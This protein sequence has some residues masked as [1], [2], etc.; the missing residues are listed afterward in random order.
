MLTQTKHATGIDPDWIL[1]DSQSTISVFRNPKTLT[2]IRKSGR[3]LRAITNGGY[4]D[5]DMVG[6][7]PNLGEVWYNSNS[8][9]NILSLAD[10]RKVCRVTMDSLVDPSMHV[11]RLDGSVMR[12]VE[13]ESGQYVYAPVNTVSANVHAYTMVSTVAEHKKMFSPRAIKAADAARA[14]YRRIGR[15]SKADF[16][17]ILRN[18]LIRNCPVTPDDAKRAL[19]IYGPDISALKGKTVKSTAEARAP[20]F[21]AVPLPAPIM[22]HHRNVTL[23]LDFFFVQGLAFFHTISRDIGFR[24]VSHVSNRSKPTILKETMAA[25]HL[26]KTRGL[27]LCDIHAD[28]EF[29]CIREDLRPVHM[30]IVPADSHVGEVE[31]SVRTIKERLRSC[32]H[33]LPFKRLPKLM[34]THM[35]ADTVRCLNQFPWQHGVSDKLSPTSIITGAA[36]PDFNNMRLEFGTYVQ[37]FEDNDPT[38]TPKARSLGAIALNPTGNA[39]GD[40]F[41]MSLAT[42]AK[43]SRHQWTEL[44]L[45]D[46]AIARVE[47]IALNEGQPLIQECGLVV[48][49]RPNQPIDDSEYD[50]DYTPPA[51]ET[52]NTLT[53]HDFDPIDND[54]LDD[55]IADAP[56]I[57]PA[58][59]SLDQ[60]A[61]EEHPQQN[62][63]ENE[64][65]DDDDDQLADDDQENETAHNDQNNEE[66]ANQDYEDYGAFVDGDNDD[67][68]APA[69][70]DEELCGNNNDNDDHENDVSAHDNQGLH[71]HN[72]DDDGDMREGELGSD[73]QDGNESY[74][75][76]AGAQPYYNLRTRNTRNDTF[77]Q[78]M[79][80]PHNGKSYFPPTHLLQHEQ[81]EDVK[82]YVFAHVMT[83]MSAKVAIRKHGKA[84]EAA[85][86]QEFA[87]LEALNVYDPIDPD[88][89]TT[90]QRREALRAINLIK[91]KRDGRLKGRTVADGRPQRSMYDKSETAS[92]TV[93]TDALL[94]SIIIDA[95]EGRDV[96]T[97][98]VAG[99]YLKADMD[100]F[101]VMKFTGESVDILCNL[102]PKHKVFVTIKDNVKVLYV[103]LV[104]AMYG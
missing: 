66:N 1:L 76:G 31:R 2:N 39:Q 73:T 6:D 15:P 72:D 59:H 33:G 35:V 53:E 43:I 8:I 104:K 83:Q 51:P 42:G 87:Q 65:A 100:D 79:D 41:F 88:T 47:A 16:Q 18:N 36:S 4:Q 82:R 75:G 71:G 89:L 70:D 97:A 24:T 55:L 81:L 22:E 80:N 40:Y 67:N 91:E 25:I 50:R 10:V 74:G 92:P 34:I 38:N 85:M 96:A 13:H 19:I 32:V 48:E 90:K 102:N 17:R 45:T 58:T 14:L 94:L 69:Y 86:M 99:A 9:A 49:W 103:K 77:K 57:D 20:T 46:T 78:A 56:L 52:D 23:C 37:V 63:D 29:E 7:F 62:D 12:F 5:S 27:R 61:A 30:N 60:G 84:A 68:D 95:H 3:I 11:H 93:S 44:P 98:D 54:E 26:Y 21:V 28:N 64:E 101:V